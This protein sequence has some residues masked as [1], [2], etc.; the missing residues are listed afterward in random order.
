MRSIEPLILP[1]EPFCIFNAAFT[2]EECQR[3]IDIGEL[4]TF[5]KGRI[6]M[7]DAGRE[8]KSVRD[9]DIVWIDPVPERH[10]LFDKVHAALQRVNFDKYQMDLA[11]F[12]A[13]QYSKYKLDGHYDWHVDTSSEHTHGLF[14]KL[15]IVIPLTSPDEY[16][17]G[18]LLINDS[19]NPDSAKALRP[20]KGHMVVFYSHLPHKVTPV[21]KGT[22]ITL[23]TWAMGAKIK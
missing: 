7:G 10:W 1:I 22:R 3:V 17:G 18:D 9:T 21:T 12:D 14:R 15:S 19:G 23:V 11:R 2:P 8:D 16:E 4:E 5:S 20:E 13:F 6:G